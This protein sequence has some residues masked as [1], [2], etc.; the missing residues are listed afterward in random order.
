MEILNK[1]IL[2]FAGH[3]IF[4]IEDGFKLTKPELDYIK[5]LQYRKH[6]NGKKSLLSKSVDILKSSKLSRLKKFIKNSQEEYVANVLEIKNKFSFVQSWAGKQSKGGHHTIHNHANHVISSVYYAKA[7]ETSLTFHT[8]KSKIEESFYFDYDIKNYNIFNSQKYTVPLK[9]GDIIFFP[10]D[11]LHETGINKSDE[12]I[13]VSASFFIN[14]KI[15]LTDGLN[16][17]NITTKINDEL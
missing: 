13:M 11:M 7:D 16:K 2:P 9:T 4:K 6:D 1:L 10:G 17:I 12:R 3:P 5:N 14:G 8:H 15:G